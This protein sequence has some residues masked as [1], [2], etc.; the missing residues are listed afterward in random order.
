MAIAA[1]QVVLLTAVSLLLFTLLRVWEKR[2]AFT[3][4]VTAVPFTPLTISNI[5]IKTA[6]M[7]LSWLLILVVMLPVITIIILSFV[8]SG[9]WMVDIYPKEFSWQNYLD[10]VTRTRK[11]APFMN[12]VTMS[13]IA[14]LIGLAVALPSSFI[15]VKTTLRLRWLLETLTM[16]PWAIPASAVA[17]NI[18]NT[19]SQATIF[20][21]N[22][23]LVGTTFLLPLAYCVRSLPVMVKITNISF[24]NLSDAVIEAS[25][26]LGATPLQTVRNIAI[27]ILRPGIMAALLVTFIRSIG[28]YTVSV[29]LYNA[30]NRPVSIAMVDAIFE[31]NIGLSMAY[32][33]LLIV[34]TG[35]LSILIGRLLQSKAL[36]RSS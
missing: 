2:T 4:P 27:P 36:K 5:F 20:T 33:T 29:L 7:V 22:T 12:S 24:Q 35:S 19:F 10:I 32:G 28:D 30:S 23:I 25:R 14:S 16:I 21:F 17:I 15:L 9:S 1:T 18:I 11:L 3:K 26:S 13:V 6:V 8:P 31:Y 34:L